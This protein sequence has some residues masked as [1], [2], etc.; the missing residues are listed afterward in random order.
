RPGRGWLVRRYARPTAWYVRGPG[1]HRQREHAAAQRA[2]GIAAAADRDRRRAQGHQPL[3]LRFASGVEYTGRIS[4]PALRG[5]Y[6]GDRSPE[7]DEL[8]CCGEAWVSVRL[9]GT[10]PKFYNAEGPRGLYWP[11]SLLGEA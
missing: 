9:Q 6:G 11:S 8:P 10:H 2:A 7:R 4:R 1:R 5:G 3:S